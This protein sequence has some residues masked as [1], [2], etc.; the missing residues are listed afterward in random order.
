MKY[1]K[2]RIAWSV[3]WGVLAVLLCVLWVRSYY[4]RESLN[5]V[6]NSNVQTV[7]SSSFGSLMFNRFDLNL[8]ESFLPPKAHGWLY[9]KYE[10][11]TGYAEPPFSFI[12]NASEW[13]IAVPHWFV[14]CILAALATSPWIRWRF[15]LRTLLIATTLVAVLL[16]AMMWAV[17]G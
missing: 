12:W 14:L 1:R 11:R 6:N 13:R 10:L 9:R 17:R 15:S 2:L 7:I 8:L 4:R 16:G 3:G 5:R